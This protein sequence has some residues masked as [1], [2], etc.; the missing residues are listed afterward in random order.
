MLFN[1]YE[2]LVWFLPIVLGGFILIGGAGQSRLAALWVTCASLLFYGWWNPSYVPLLIG[3]MTVNYWLGSRLSANRS[4]G[5][6][7]FGVA[8]NL[9]L[10]G[11]Y[12]YTGFALGA[13][14]QALGLD[15]TIPHIALPLAI[16]FFTFQ[17]IAF[18]S[19]AYDGEAEEHN[20]LDYCLFITFFPHLIA[21]PITHHREMLPQFRGEGKFR[22]RPE[23]LAVGLTLFALGLFKKVGIADPFGE[24]ARPV[25]SA[26]AGG[27]A[28]HLTESWGGATAYA[29]Q[30][31][32]DFSGYTDMA[33]GLGIMFGIRLPQNFDSPYKARS[34]IEFWSR[35]H[36]TLTRFLTAYV[37]NPLVLRLTRARARAGLPLMR[38]GQATTGA[39]IVLVAL[40]TILTMFLSGVWHGAGWQFVIFGLLHGCYLTVNHA[41]RAT[42]RKLGWGDRQSRWR[43]AVAV[44][45]TFACVT[46]ALVFFRAADVP[47]A[48]RLV[49]GMAGQN[50]LVVHPTLAGAPG[51]AQIVDLLGIRV[52]ESAYFNSRQLAWVLLGLVIVWATPNTQQWMQRY[53]TALGQKLRP[54]WILSWLPGM[55]WRPTVVIGLLMGCVTTFSLMKTFSQAPTEF[56]YFQF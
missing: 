15:W 29:L 22:P 53:S 36:M 41:W 25:F 27:A 33:I 14:D 35:W 9:A 19:D 52:S 8:L 45:T 13:I 37:Y 7:L 1:S 21:G 43:A 48:L 49:A 24:I 40:P 42:K 39:F 11:Y 20:F 4:K 56:L 54:D 31:Y 30:I 5:L 26:A 10:L 55:V 32:F 50:G 17:Q 12:K 23:H 2:F 3:S 44:L 28:L 18:L 34:I 46:I 47:T 6:L 38:K 16:S 51:L